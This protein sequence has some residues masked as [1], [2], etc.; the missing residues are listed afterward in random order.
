MAALYRE[1]NPTRP[2]ADVP[3]AALRKK[4]RLRD[5]PPSAPRQNRASGKKRVERF[6]SL[7]RSFVLESIR[8]ALCGISQEM[9]Q[10]GARNPPYTPEYAE[11]PPSTGMTMPVTKL[12]AALFSRNISAPTSSSGL[13]KRSMGVAARIF[14][15]RGVGVPSS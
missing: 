8:K 12:A 11:N 1:R 9:P 14:P 15:V 13:P 5:F 3:A 7:A 6:D 10:R 4:C 2:A